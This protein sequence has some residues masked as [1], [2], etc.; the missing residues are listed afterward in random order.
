M[1]RIVVDPVVKGETDPTPSD[2]EIS[3]ESTYT[4]YDRL[5]PE[6][7]KALVAQYGSVEAVKRNPFFADC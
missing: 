2:V 7:Q 5:P 4:C 3:M 6:T 1:K